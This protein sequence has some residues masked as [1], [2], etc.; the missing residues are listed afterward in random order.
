VLGTVALDR[1]G[2]SVT[3]ESNL[4]GVASNL[5]RHWLVCIVTK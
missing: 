2:S 1:D 4:I 5:F 3:D